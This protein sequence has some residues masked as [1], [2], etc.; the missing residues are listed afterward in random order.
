MSFW[1]FS[2]RKS[3]SSLYIKRKGEKYLQK[4]RKKKESEGKQCLIVCM[5]WRGYPKCDAEIYPECIVTFYKGILNKTYIYILINSIV[6]GKVCSVNP[7]LFLRYLL[8]DLSYE[9]FGKVVF[10]N[11]NCPFF[12]LDMHVSHLHAWPTHRSPVFDTRHPPWS[13]SCAASLCVRFFLLF[14]H[15]RE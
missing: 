13:F 7:W 4:T 2:L 8:I 6:Y 9:I 1:V 3:L 12:D 5:L 14:L 10:L 11:P 15:V